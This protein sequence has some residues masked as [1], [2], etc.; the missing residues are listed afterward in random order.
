VVPSAPTKGNKPLAKDVP[1]HSVIKLT[2]RAA[3]GSAG[4]FKFLFSETCAHHSVVGID[5]PAT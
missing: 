5:T 3:T 2:M 4:N 1:A